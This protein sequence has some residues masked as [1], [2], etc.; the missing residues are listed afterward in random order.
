MIDTVIFDVGGV[1]SS[2]E[3]VTYYLHQGYSRQMSERLKKATMDHPAWKEYDRGVLTDEEV[4]ARFKKDAPDLASEIDAS[5]V[6]MHGLVTRRDTSIPW[7]TSLKA[8]N[9][10]VFVL[11]NF[12]R[13]AL[14]DCADALDFRTY[15]D[16]CF[17]SC[18]HQVIKPDPAAFLTLFYL[19]HIDPCH[20][21]F[22]DDTLANIIS[23]QQ[24][25]LHGIHY[26]SQSQAE[27]DLAKL[28]VQQNT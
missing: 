17:F 25:G 16:D 21:V 8:Q 23:A 20:A 4:R 9:M 19:F 2:Y 12:A 28:L 10:K 27:T 24:F 14:Q 7:I 3:Q 5:L 22:I 13:T 11:S 18:Q 1:L 15:C 26:Q 6:H